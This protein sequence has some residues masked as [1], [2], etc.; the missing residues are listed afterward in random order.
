MR[1]REIRL[2]RRLAV[3]CA[4][5]ILC[6]L[7][8]AGS[9]E[10][11]LHQF[12]AFPHGQF[13]DGLI[14][15]T[16]GNFYG[17]AQGGL[18]NKGVVYRLT[19]DSNGSLTENVLYNFMG[20]LD[21]A[22]PLGVAVDVA[23]NLYGYT[24]GGGVN[25]AGVFFDLMPSASGDW[26]ESV[27]YN[28]TALADG[29]IANGPSIDGSGNIFG[30]AYGY[31]PAYGFIFELSPSTGGTWTENVLYTFSGGTDGGQPSGNFAFDRAGNLY[32]TASQG[33][34]NKSGVVFE[35]TPAA[36]GTWN[37][38][39]LYNFAGGDDGSYPSWGGIFDQDGSLYG[40]TEYGG[41]AAGCTSSSGCGTVF[42]LKP[43]SG[44]QWTESVLYS[45]GD[46]ASAPEGVSPSPL[47]IDSAGNLFGTTQEGGRSAITDQCVNGC[48]TVFEVSP[49]AGGQW[50]GSVLHNF[51]GPSAYDPAGSMVV[52]PGGRLYG[53]TYLGGLDGG[54]NGTVFE[55]A[56]N[57]N[58]EWT[59]STAYAFPTTDGNDSQSDL[60]ADAAGNLYGTTIGGGTYGA[61]AVFELSPSSGGAWNEQIL[62]SFTETN[63]FTAPD[64]DGPYGDLVMDSAGHLYGT[65]I[66]GGAAYSGTVFELSPTPGGGWDETVL[67]SFAGGND[68]QSPLAGLVFDGAGNLYGTT[69]EG[70]LYNWGTV[71]KLAPGANGTWTE[72]VIHT[73]TGFPGD[74]RAPQA[75][76][77]VDAEGN[78]Y[79][80]TS[81][82]GNGA[83]CLVGRNNPQGCGTVFKLSPGVGGAWNETVLYSFTNANG[84]GAHP[85]A[86]LIFDGA[87]NLYGTTVE[88][89]VAGDCAWDGLS[90]CGTVFELSPSSGG[91][92]KENVL[93][94]FEG[95]KTDGSNPATELV[96]DAAGN[97]YGTTAH[98]GNVRDSLYSSGDGTVF[99]LSPTTGGEWAET[100]LHNFGQGSDGT[101]PQAGLFLDGSGNLYGTT[102]GVAA[103]GSVVFEVTP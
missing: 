80:T 65:T 101:L 60:I 41:N 88:G 18:Y 93:Y 23:G 33:G 95:F 64:G 73:F 62:Y 97:L 52:G 29:Y 7:R 45:F 24:S 85:L 54:L 40:V 102:A 79:G 20:G 69:V 103:T 84:D 68:G 35:L 89:G 48:G 66:D 53:T 55:L 19:P 71:F 44:G 49:G 90:T 42:Q 50:T 38:T 34:S 27:L 91:T 77:I 61:G 25:R 13:P 56:P 3:F 78:L 86:S 72:S 58:G 36:G 100:V 98:G 17:T 12:S 28:F 75:G 15:D 11:V 6:S 51:I 47:L 70:G 83:S 76:L 59:T 16:M 32:G 8:A 2:L 5:L 74:G 94:A 21:G 4:T 39:V 26:K 22:N 67:Y 30:E 31:S 87:G 63:H 46:P 81:Q 14:A 10:K 43:G 96:F 92:W 99:E 1:P 57:G 9:T 37:E 82:G